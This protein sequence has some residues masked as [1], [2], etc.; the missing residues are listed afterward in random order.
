MTIERKPFWDPSYAVPAAEWFNSLEAALTWDEI[1][2]QFIARFT[3]GKIQYQFRIE[4]ESL[5]KQLEEDMKSHIH[6]SKI[7]VDKG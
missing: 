1:K 2:T 7:L 6:R 4:A 5:K 3:E